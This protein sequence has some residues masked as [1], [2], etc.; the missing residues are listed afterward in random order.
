RRASRNVDLAAGAIGDQVARVVPAGWQVEN[1]LPLALDFCL[2]SAV[3]EAYDSIGVRHVEPVAHEQ[4]AVGHIESG[5]ENF[6]DIRL[7]VFIGISE[8]SDL[9][10]RFLR[11]MCPPGPGHSRVAS[12]TNMS[13]LGK[14]YA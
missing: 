9:I 11:P 13:P 2:A 8:Q 1:F 12:T 7:A 4:H 5:Q 3:E 14:T 10:P 6:T